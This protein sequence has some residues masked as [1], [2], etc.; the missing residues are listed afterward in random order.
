V[1]HQS[2]LGIFHCTSYLLSLPPCIFSLFLLL[3][4]NYLV[5][6]FTALKLS[7]YRAVGKFFSVLLKLAKKGSSLTAAFLYRFPFF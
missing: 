7:F 6:V 4:V 2:L 1:S 3:E 5:C